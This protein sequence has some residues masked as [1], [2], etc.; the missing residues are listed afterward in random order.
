[1]QSKYHCRKGRTYRVCCSCGVKFTYSLENMSVERHVPWTQCPTGSTC[2]AHESRKQLRSEDDSHPVECVEHERGEPVI[3]SASHCRLA[4]VPDFVAVPGIA[5][6]AEGKAGYRRRR[7][8]DG[9][10]GEWD[11]S[12]L[13]VLD[14]LANWES[15]RPR[16]SGFSNRPRETLHDNRFIASRTTEFTCGNGPTEHLA[17]GG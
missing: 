4:S 14:S 3:K 5:K 12:F 11:I 7:S 1:M 17:S 9:A 10:R 16:E 8:R 6:A 15:T 2:C 13:G